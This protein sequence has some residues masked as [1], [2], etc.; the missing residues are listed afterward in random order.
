MSSLEELKETVDLVPVF[1][2]S[3]EI[4]KIVK[5]AIGK[6]NYL[7]LQDGIYNKEV[8][9]IADDANIGIVMDKCIMVEHKEYFV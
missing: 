3:E 2:P 9:K 8:E 6:T 5:Q 1:R 4:P 7:W